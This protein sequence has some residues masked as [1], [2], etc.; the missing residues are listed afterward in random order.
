MAGNVVKVG[1]TVEFQTED[2]LPP[3]KTRGVVE[4]IS[5]NDNQRDSSAFLKID[6]GNGMKYNIAAKA[7][8]ANSAESPRNSRSR[9]VYPD[10]LTRPAATLSPLG[11]GE[12]RG[13]R[14]LVLI[15]WR[16]R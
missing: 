7:V 13:E 2:R 14:R 1:A 10:P 12:G 9:I 6:L 16:C 3:N 11:R 5:G 15:H 4:T 8:T